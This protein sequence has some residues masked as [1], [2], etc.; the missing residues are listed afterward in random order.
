MIEWKTPDIDFIKANRGVC[1]GCRRFGSDTAPA[2]IFLLGEKY[3]TKVAVLNGAMLR[4][5]NGYAP[6]R[7]GYGFPLFRGEADLRAITDALRRDADERGV[8]FGFCLCDEKQKTALDSV[9]K[10]DWSFTDDDSDYIYKRESLAA[11][12]GKKLHRKRNHISGFNRLYDDAEYRP[13][14][15][16]NAA[17]AYKVAELW[18]AEREG[19][20]SEDERAE[21]VSI[22]AALGNMEALGLLGGVLYVGGV[23]AAMTVAS[24]I[25]DCVTDVHY[26][27]SFGEYAAN[28]AFTVINQCFASSGQSESEYF[29]R[30]EDMGIEG[31]KTAKESYFPSFKLKKYYGVCRC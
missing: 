16:D 10:T 8:P 26:E 18:L 11:L 30:E 5:Y 2:N 19:H 6:N 21:L 17:D 9:L 22:R 3:G 27:K 28:G 15:P 4:Y 25:S 29:N 20:G 1:G 31:L 14:T 13:L 24:Q 23:P 7:R 12:A